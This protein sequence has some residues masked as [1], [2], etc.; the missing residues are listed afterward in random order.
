[1]DEMAVSR[2]IEEERARIITSLE[3][4]K[5]RDITKDS[6]GILHI[7]EET[8]TKNKTQEVK[9]TELVGNT[10][11]QT[12]EET[13]THLTKPS[14]SLELFATKSYPNLLREPL[15]EGLSYGVNLS[16]RILGDFWMGVYANT[17]K[18]F[19]LSARLD[20]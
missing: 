16:Y 4:T 18:E 17:E 15:N 11:L 6:K 1:V 20:F 10:S 13:Q 9:H 2:A 3:Q 19:G 5:T 12:H 14:F 7:H 8:L